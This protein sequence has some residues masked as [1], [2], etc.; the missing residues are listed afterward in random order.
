MSHFVFG[1]VIGGICF[2]VVF[3]FIHVRARRKLEARLS[4]LSKIIVDA[5]KNSVKENNKAK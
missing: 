3:N 1:F 4:R 2:A 5:L